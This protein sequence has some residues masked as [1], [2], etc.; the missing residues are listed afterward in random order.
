MRK[1]YVSLFTLALAAAVSITSTA[2]EI[3]RESLTYKTI[4]D[5]QLEMAVYSPVDVKPDDARAAAVFYF[6]GGWRNG[7]ISQFEPQAIYLAKRGMVVFTPEYRVFSRHQ[8]TP[9][10]C[11]QDARSAVRWVRNQ[12]NKYGIDPEKIL[13]GGGSAGG[14]LALCTTLLDEYDEPG[15]DTSTSCKANAL[16]LFNPATNTTKLA[17]RY[18][19]TP[20]QAEALSPLHHVA[21]DLPSAIAFHGVADKTV[22]YAHATDFEEAMKAAGNDYQLCSFEEAGHGFFNLSREEGKYYSLTLELL[23]EFLAKLGYLEETA[24]SDE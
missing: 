24:A 10:V 15:E 3:K 7:S 14:H 19:F 20:E 12:A 16:A 21:S 18:G 9:D 23:D 13:V 2:G 4:G 5:V 6:G 22:P 1:I 17:N 8:V 11:V